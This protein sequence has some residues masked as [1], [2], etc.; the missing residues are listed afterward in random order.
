MKTKAKPEAP[1]TH[2]TKEV[3]ILT[4]EQ[5]VAQD[6]KRFD[7]MEALEKIKEEAKDLKIE[8]IEDREG[9]QK[10]KTARMAVVRLRTGIE[11]IRSQLN[12][13]ALK[14]QRLVNDHAKKLTAKVRE[15]E[16]PLDA[17][18]TR[19]DNLIKEEE[20][21]KLQI[22][23]DRRIERARLLS[24]MG[25]LFDGIKYVGH[26]TTID[27]PSVRE[28]PDSEF[29]EIVSEIRASYLKEK[30]ELEERE[31]I[32]KEEE[33]RQAKER[34][35]LD[36]RRA[37]LERMENEAA[38]RVK[39]MAE[40][41]EAKR[42]EKEAE[43]EAEREARASIRWEMLKALG[44]EIA[45][46][47]PQAWFVLTE[48]KERMA[49]LYAINSVGTPKVYY[50]NAEEFSA[51]LEELKNLS[52][53]RR[54]QIAEEEKQKQAARDLEIQEA[55]QRAAKEAEDRIL[56]KQE[57]ERAEAEAK[58]AAEAKAKQEEEARIAREEAL[59]PDREKLIKFAEEL[60]VIE[61]PEVVSEAAKSVLINAE[62]KLIELAGNLKE[63]A[64]KL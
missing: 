47:G 51:T 16:D 38:E 10:V 21:R 43:A 4:I 37:E 22:I 61:L 36:A 2:E 39:K 29:G 49:L 48:D 55:Q 1:E 23:E 26:G 42:K 6:V 45:R 5:R 27:M 56:K 62:N 53:K 18:E 17:E 7:V 63:I 15:I 33:E 9:Y 50:Q 24:E 12:E 34:E 20:A 11:K 64:K 19:I 14:Y 44:I 59:R 40:E 8:G 35:E 3:A 31:R 52:Q 58:A 46:S 57:A 28:L 54:D 60:L 13:D 32:R 25:M 30:S 41:E